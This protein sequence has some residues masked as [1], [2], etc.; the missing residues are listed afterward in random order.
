MHE[1]RLGTAL[2]GAPLLLIHGSATRAGLGAGRRASHTLFRRDPVHNRG[3]G[4]SDAPPGPY[5]TAELADDAVQVLYEAGVE[6]RTSS[7]RAWRNGR[8]GAR[9]RHPERVEKLVLACTTP[10]GPQA[11]PMPQRSV[12]L[13]HARATLRSTSRTRSSPNTR[14]ELVDRILEHRERTRS[15]RAVAAQAAR[16]DFRR[17]R[18]L[19][20][21]SRSS[22]TRRD[23]RHRATPISRGDPTPL[24]L[25]VPPLHVRPH[26]VTSYFF[27]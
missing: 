20:Y 4:E 5:T 27:Y 17:L 24:R 14:L 19:P 11:F 13:M 16:S 1:D 15:L 2:K 10:G 6:R 25:S 8:A 3:V 12:D 23:V 22:S 18:Q 7:A 21:R 9:S 26:F